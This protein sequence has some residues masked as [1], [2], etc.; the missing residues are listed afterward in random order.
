MRELAQLANVSVSTVS[1]AFGNAEDVS[2]ETRE[3]I[4]NV[5]REAGCFG[6]YYRERFQKKIFAIICSEL[7]GVYYISFVERLQ[8]LIEANGGIALISADHFDS[9]KQAELI[10][11]YASYLR[12]DGIF[13]FGLKVPMKKG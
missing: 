5:A 1:K 8:R 3:H 9:K 2:P 13:V 4:F 12:V 7:V 11:Y 10:D 6:K